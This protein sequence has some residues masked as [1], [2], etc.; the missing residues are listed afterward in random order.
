MKIEIS[1][2]F[3][4]FSQRLDG[5]EVILPKTNDIF[6]IH[7]ALIIVKDKENIVLPI[8]G[9]VNN[10]TVSLDILRAE[11]HVYGS[12]KKGYI[13]YKIF[14]S[15][16]GYAFETLKDQT[17]KLPFKKKSSV[18]RSEP[19]FEKLSLGIH[20]KQD[21][22][23]MQK[24]ADLKELLPF[25]FLI[26][27]HITKSSSL[28]HKNPKDY[29]ELIQWYQLS[30]KSFFI[31]Y[32]NRYLGI[33]NFFNTQ[34]LPIDYLGDFGQIIRDLFIEEKNENLY[35]LPHLFPEFPCGRMTDI[36]LFDGKIF[37]SMEWS[38]KK[39][40][41][42]ILKTKHTLK[43]NLHFPSEVDRFRV[44]SSFKDTGRVMF[45]KTELVI[46]GQQILYLD[47]FI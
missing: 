10:F 20:K 16:K 5:I 23:A 41:K 2:K 18:T 44:R 22:D 43:L 24:R 28:I 30:F 39:I 17:S 38:K 21:V 34:F 1:N 8:E 35:I 40:A 47:R 37:L 11:I 7:P 42:V 4:P 32:L 14:A 19:C 33:E 12:T 25:V 9:P 13:H 31:P 27:Q 15:E 45:N 3:I 46:D 29:Q 6:I 26:S 36:K